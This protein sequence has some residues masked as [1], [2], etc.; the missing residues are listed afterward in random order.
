MEKN[1]PNE[2][3]SSGAEVKS[4]FKSKPLSLN[5]NLCA[6]SVLQELGL[7]GNNQQSIKP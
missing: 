3:T 5:A 1:I 4:K 2:N 7:D 6:I